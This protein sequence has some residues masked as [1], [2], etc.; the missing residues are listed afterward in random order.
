MV[1]CLF[2]RRTILVGRR[3]SMEISTI[4]ID[5]SKTTL[6]LSKVAALDGLMF[7]F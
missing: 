5:L 1:L 4:K 3:F 6:F 2:H 7:D